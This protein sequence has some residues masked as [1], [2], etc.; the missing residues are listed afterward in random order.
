M[1]IYTLRKKFIVFQFIVFI[2]AIIYEYYLMESQDYA[3]ILLYSLWN[4]ISYLWLFIMEL[5]YAPDFHPYQ[6]LA[7]ISAQFIGFNGISCYNELT[8]GE[9][10]Y[11]G[12]T[13]INDAM[14]LGI[15]YLSL[16]HIL[17]FAIFFILEKKNSKKISSSSKLADKIKR[18]NI[19]YFVWALKFYGFVWIMRALSSVIPLASISSILVSVT[20]M[21]HIITLFLLTF[22]MIQNPKK[23]STQRLHWLIVLIEIILVLNHGMKEEIIR[24]LV[25]Y[26]I[27]ILIMYKAG[28]IS[29]KGK[30]VIQIGAISAF[31]ILFVFPYVSIFR[32]IS[33]NTGKSWDQIS[34]SETLAEYNNYI[35]KEGVYANDDEERGVGYLMSRAGSIGCNAFSIDYA[36][37][38]GS[39]PDFFAYCGMAL[40]PRI[41]WPNKP[42]ILIGG[43]I[44]SLAVGENNWMQASNI[45]TK[46]NSL[47]LGYIGACYFCL[48]FW[49]AI[50]L[51]IIHAS[52]IWYL[53]FF[54]KQAMLYN[55]VALWAFSSMLFI[56]LKDFES[57]GDCG[58]NFIIFNL[59]YIFICKYIYKGSQKSVPA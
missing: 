43:M 30:Y 3:F 38:N 56:L 59:I 9:N 8:N 15:I 29:L 10:I 16:Q 58:L 32:N 27:Y 11:F 23:A 17:L 34:V 42:K 14:P 46:G 7:L 28:Y 31:V 39:S 54:F 26:C 57:F 53:W 33:I 22:S 2:I 55:I 12:N 1:N 5:K 25:P 47:S 41:I 21:G 36:K 52:L 35:N 6:I 24:T 19:N 49:G 51:I 44:N 4:S 50:L 13:L 45:E 40:I 18:S 37:K 48:G 20:N